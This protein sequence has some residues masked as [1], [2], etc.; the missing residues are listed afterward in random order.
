[1]GLYWNVYDIEELMVV[2]VTH[3]YYYLNM[4]NTIRTFVAE[5]IYQG[6]I[7]PRAKQSKTIHDELT[8]YSIGLEE[9]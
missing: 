8:I 6:L 3:R 7:F 4:R 1:M 2:I 9:N 5:E